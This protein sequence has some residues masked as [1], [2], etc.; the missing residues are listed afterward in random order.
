MLTSDQLDADV[1]G[2]HDAV[3][4]PFVPKDRSEQLARCVA[5]HSVDI[6]V[7]WHDAAEAGLANRSL[8][9]EELLIPE[10][11]PT[12]VDRRLVETTFRHA[13]A[14][15]VLAGGDHPVA[16]GRSLQGADIGHAHR[17]REVRILPIGLLDPTPTRVAGDVENGAKRVSGARGEHSS[18]DSR[19]N[20]PEQLRVEGGGRADRLLEA[21][22][23]P[24]KQAVE[25]LLMDDRRNPEP[26]PLD[27]VPLDLVGGACHFGGL[28][29]GGSRESRDLSQTRSKELVELPAV[30]PVVADDLEGPDRSELC[31]LLL[32]RHPA[33]Q[34]G[35]PFVDGQGRI[36]VV[37]LRLHQPFTA[38]LPRPAMIWR[39]A[40]M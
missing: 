36:L 19:G 9:R 29:V 27:E 40:P 33:K 16:E 5:G 14:D 39:S 34:I 18:P 4:P 21:R 30:E 15:E 31:D 28:Q 1:V 22:R 17:G 11:S 37:Q 26:R 7:G 24:G 13:V 10:L 20:L 8:E 6:T 3:K 25:T 38:P 2:R 32:D 12:N 35:N 23:R